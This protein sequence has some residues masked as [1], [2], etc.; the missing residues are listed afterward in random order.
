MSH[1]RNS[2]KVLLSCLSM[3]SMPVSKHALANALGVSRRTI[4]RWKQDGMPSLAVRGAYRSPRY[5]LRVCQDWASNLP[6]QGRSRPTRPPSTPDSLILN[7]RSTEPPE[8]LSDN[9]PCGG[10]ELPP[11]PAERLEALGGVDGE[12]DWAT[13]A[14]RIRTRILAELETVP[15]D[16]S[17]DLRNFTVA[18]VQIERLIADT[19]GRSKDTSLREWAEVL[20]RIAKRRASDNP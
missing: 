15:L 10:I 8:P 7:L 18:A 6:T 17:T 9:P 4:E 12:R 19:Q 20:E 1:F 11:T 5:D 13:I 3:S 2:D 16:T 14:A